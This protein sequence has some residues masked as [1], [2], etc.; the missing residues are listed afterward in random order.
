[1]TTVFR[2]DSMASNAMKS[3]NP[4]SGYATTT[5]SKTLDVHCLNPACNQG[6][7]V[8]VVDL[9]DSQLPDG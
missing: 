8:I 1:M 4:H 6:G 7:I 2:I 9:R 5:I 3:S